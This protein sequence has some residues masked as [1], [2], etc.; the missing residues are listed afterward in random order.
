MIVLTPALRGFLVKF[1][2]GAAGREFY[3]TGGGALA[4]FYLQHRHSQDLDLFT[5]E[6]TAWQNV[7]HDLDVSANAVGAE[8]EFRPAQPPNE[9]HRAFLRV[10]GEAEIKIDI[11]RDT[12]PHFGGLNFQTDGVI[13]DSF[14]NIAVGKLSALCG[15]AYPRDYVD[16]Y[17]LLQ[18]GADFDRLVALSIEKDPGINH[19]Y[20][21]QMLALVEKLEQRDLPELLKPIDLQAMKI[22]FLQLANKLV[23]KT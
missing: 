15:R 5:Q 10:P 6:T 13:V 16:V 20:V 18:S 2:A 22:F 17:L 11:V 8:I 9:L 4:E 23:N 12:P 3:L 14:E 1:F 21:A 19:L 7:Q